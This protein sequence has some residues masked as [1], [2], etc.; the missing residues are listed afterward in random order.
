MLGNNAAYDLYLS[1][2]STNNLLKLN[3]MRRPYK[4]RLT[5]NL[6]LVQDSIITFVILIL[7][8]DFLAFIKALKII[9]PKRFR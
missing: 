1:M 3:R 5:T 8:M 7:R 9:F 2:V 6:K 4:I